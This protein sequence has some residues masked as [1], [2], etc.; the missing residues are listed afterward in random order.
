MRKL[1]V[2]IAILAGTSALLSAESVK[3]TQD[4]I[5]F[6][7]L[8]LSGNIS[9]TLCEGSKYSV[10]YE[11]DSRIVDFVS[12]HLSGSVLKIE[13]REKDFPNELKA[14]IRKKE[15]ALSP[16]NFKVTA[17]FKSFS[18]ISL[19]DNAK[20]EVEGSVEVDNTLKIKT[21]NNSKILHSLIRAK[22]VEVSSHNNSSIDASFVCD[23][24]NLETFNNASLSLNVSS[25][26][27]NIEASNNAS[28]IIS[29]EVK[30]VEIT[31]KNNSELDLRKTTT[32]KVEVKMSNNCQCQVAT[33]GKLIIT[34]M[35][36]GADLLFEGKPT[37]EIGKIVNSSVSSVKPSDR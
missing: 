34:S 13:I 19:E 26:S 10:T 25:K 27:A 36:G 31:G 11:V 8:S 33:D 29:G 23:A 3:K 32:D 30:E 14:Q 20:I 9:A 1:L 4:L 35:T 17:P 6:S 21:L 16:S 15:F 37:L 22:K 12:V 28:V 5:S 2:F 18:S 7:G 24:L